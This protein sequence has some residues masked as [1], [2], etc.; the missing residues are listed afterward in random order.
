MRRL[1]FPLLSAVAVAL[2]LLGGCDTSVS[3]RS[4]AGG[5]SIRGYLQTGLPQGERQFIRVRDLNRPLDDSSNQQLDATVT[6]EN[7][8]DGT[9]ETLRD[10]VVVFDGVVT[11]NFWT[12]TPIQPAATYRVRVEGTDGR[13][14]TTST[15]TPTG[16]DL[17]PN[18]DVSDCVEGFHFQFPAGSNVYDVDVLYRYEDRVYRQDY[19]SRLRSETSGPP[20]LRLTPESDLIGLVPT[21]PALG[22]SF[23]S[24]PIYTRCPYLDS[25]FVEVAYTLVSDDWSEETGLDVNFNPTTAL[26]VEDGLGFFGSVRR[27]TVA[28]RV[29]QTVCIYT[30]RL[31]VP[32]EVEGL[33]STAVEVCGLT[34]EGARQRL[35]DNGN[36]EFCPPEEEEDDDDDG[37][38]GGPGGR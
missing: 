28:V 13:V 36:P 27:D 24:G 8:T 7:V 6:L 16:T 32:E 9:A 4:G 31:P 11:H 33:V 19:R 29:N 21:P 34:L 18:A 10:E 23:P 3:P 37:G 22:P 15:T 25:P 38:P 12:D 30:P 1:L 20:R 14:T 26:G 2:L 35:C 17:A 5:F